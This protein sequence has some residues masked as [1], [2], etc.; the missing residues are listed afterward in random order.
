MY[1]ER[2]MCPALEK[3]IMSAAE[4]ASFISSGMTLGMS[5]F[6]TGAPKAIPLEIVKPGNVRDLTVIQGAGLGL[7]DELALSGA[8]SRYCAFQWSRNMRS[9]INAGKVAFSDI[10]LGQLADK[11]R[12]GTFGKI[13]YAI[14]ECARINEDGGIVPSISLGVSNVLLECADKVLLE[15]NKA[16][17]AE[18]EGMHDVYENDLRPLDG[19][20]ERKGEPV[21]RCDLNKIA[22]IVITDEEEPKLSFRDT[23]EVYQD[24]AKQVLSLLDSEIREKRLPQEFT[25]QAGVGGVANAVLQGLSEGGYKGLNMFTEVLA[26]GAL[27]FIGSGVISEAST[28]ALDLSPKGLKTFFGNIDFYKE[29]IVLR[30]LEV[31]NGVSQITAMGL[32]AMNTALEAD[33]YGN[34]NSTNAIGMKM[35]NGIGG[36]NDFCRSAKLSI[37]IT[38]STAKNGAISSIVPMVSHVDSTEHDVDIIATEYGYADLRGKS[39]KERAAE[40]IENCAHPYYR[41]PLRDYYSGAVALCGPCQTPHDLSKALSWHQRFIETGS[42]KQ[43]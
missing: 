28:T 14:I 2:M 9:A 24:I 32:V 27:G 40:I 16:V 12:G 1:S 20:L 41:Q 19:V 7:L 15:I 17:P 21:F 39:P 8:V 42:M 31:S 30:P 6:S 23:N 38:P 43:D 3:R 18:I 35:L 4:A 37:F 25:L 36:S 33:I 29:H 34:I 10:H 5:G 13:D 11:I 26:D 22:G